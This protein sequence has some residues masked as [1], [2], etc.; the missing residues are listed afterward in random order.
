MRES[1]K[2]TG[3]ERWIT[4]IC[5]EYENVWSV[6]GTE[7]IRKRFG[8]RSFRHG[9]FGEG[10]LWPSVKNLFPDEKKSVFP[11]ECPQTRFKTRIIENYLWSSRN[12]RCAV[13]KAQFAWAVRSLVFSGFSSAETRNVLS[14]RNEN[15]R[16][17]IEKCAGTKF[18]TVSKIVFFFSTTNFLVPFEGNK[19]WGGRGEKNFVHFGFDKRCTE[20]DRRILVSCF[21]A[22]SSIYIDL[23][24]AWPKRIFLSDV[25]S[26]LRADIFIPL[27]RLPRLNA[28]T[29]DESKFIGFD[30]FL[31]N[32]RIVLKEVRTRNKRR[33][34]HERT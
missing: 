12:G 33:E 26:C 3:L 14:Y 2:A 27:M 1:G 32:G 22:G 23:F 13:H 28:I 31:F 5:E 18:Y 20:R 29:R 16:K 9:S 6:R 11:I 24:L 10:T 7:K 25:V 17:W 34:G 19:D 4:Q 21:T 15:A 30:R 8:Q